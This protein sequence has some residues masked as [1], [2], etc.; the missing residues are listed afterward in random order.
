MFPVAAYLA[1]A[2]LLTCLFW[3]A[4]CGA[5]SCDVL[6][7]DHCWSQVIVAGDVVFV[8][9]IRVSSD[10]SI[11]CWLLH[12]VAGKCVRVGSKGTRQDG[13]RL[14]VSWAG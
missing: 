13:M 2:A 5:E 1:E 10:K 11:P 3:L 12:C 6:L 7:H 14:I 4:A 9:V 8:V